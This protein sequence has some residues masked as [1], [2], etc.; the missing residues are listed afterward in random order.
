PGRR[1]SP[2]GSR[3]SPRRSRLRSSPIRPGRRRARLSASPTSSTCPRLLLVLLLLAV[4]LLAVLLLLLMA[5]FTAL[6]E[7]RA[8][9][10]GADEARRHRG[11]G[12]RRLRDADAA[13]FALAGGRRRWRLQVAAVDADVVDVE[14]FCVFVLR[15]QRLAGLDEDVPA[16][17]RVAAEVDV[18]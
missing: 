14:L 3:S 6:V 16:V 13:F 5:A 4:L 12:G 18:L 1:W 11:Q 2:S 10:A 9:V 8:V 7:G 15:H 17:R